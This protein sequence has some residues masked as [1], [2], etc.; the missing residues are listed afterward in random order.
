MIHQ[1]KKDISHI[2]IPR[3]FNYPFYNS[4]HE[5]SIIAAHELK[6]YLM[7]V[8]WEHNFGLD[9]AKSTL[10][11]GKMF[12]V[13]IVKDQLDNLS[14]LWAYS[15]E[16]QGSNPDDS[17]VPNVIEKKL[18]IE[19][20]KKEVSKINANVCRLD[21]EIEKLKPLQVMAEKEIKLFREKMVLAKIQRKQKRSD[22]SETE[23]NLVK[24]S[25]HMKYL[26]KVLKEKWDEKLIELNQKVSN[27]EELILK[28][29]TLL[30]KLQ[31]KQFEQYSFFNGLKE[32]K[33]LNEI[34]EPIIYNPPPGSGDCAA[35]KLLHFAYKNNLV[36]IALNEFWWGESPKGEV[37]K[38]KSFYPACTSRCGPIL[39][40]MLKGLKVEPNPMLINTGQGKEIVI[41]FEDDD[42]YV[43]NKPEGLLSVSG[44][45]IKDSVESRLENSFI[46]HRLD[47]ETSGL[48]IV[49]KNKKVQAHIQKQF[50][51]KSINKTYVA[52][53]A[54]IIPCEE[55]EI[56][57][58]LTL[59]F[60]NRPRQKVCAQTGK[61]SLTHFKVLKR[62]T[63]ETLVH[64]FPKTGRTHQ[65]RMHSA[66]FKGLNIPIKGDTLYGL[67]DERL[68]LHAE[69]IEFKHPT[70]NQT[71]QFT[72]K[73]EFADSF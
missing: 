1:F 53:V 7:S 25:L 50:V 17:F 43:I 32:S 13:L 37:R 6:E 46:V 62:N 33:N 60:N 39:T 56:S 19:N 61:P 11:I 64:F 70:T 51:A 29:K 35:P 28:R 54:G 36:P 49:A 18:N 63:N 30:S 68:F 38:H 14:V 20:E 2:Q 9:S 23:S 73:A 71:L 22:L 27:K 41:I 10:K 31:E 58:P 52:I 48:M 21:G 65:L 42:L 59:D 34:F 5:L 66:H 57:L 40:H 4:P 16:L 12:G 55:G 45:T 8:Q 67:R 26:F 44:K 24:E 69:S 15:G 72:S 3:L 47:Q